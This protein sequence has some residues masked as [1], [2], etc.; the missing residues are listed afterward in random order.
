MAA[1]CCNKKDRKIGGMLKTVAG[2]NIM[3]G[4]EIGIIVQKQGWDK[5]IQLTVSQQFSFS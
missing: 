5:V 1:K 3:I 2:D 4:Y